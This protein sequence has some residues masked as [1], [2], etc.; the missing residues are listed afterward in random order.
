[1]NSKLASVVNYMAANMGLR[2]APAMALPIDWVDPNPKPGQKPDV[3]LGERA[4]RVAPSTVMFFTSFI[5]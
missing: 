3:K 1:M 4:E 2:L 5:G